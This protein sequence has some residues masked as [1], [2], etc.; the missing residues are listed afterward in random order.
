MLDLAKIRP[1]T[2]AAVRNEDG[3]TLL[4]L[5]AVIC[6][7]GVIAAIYVPNFLNHRQTVGAEV[8]KADLL[9][10]S[11]PVGAKYQEAPNSTVSLTRAMFPAVQA[12]DGTEWDVVSGPVGYCLSAWNPGSPEHKTAET[13]LLLEQQTGDCAALGVSGKAV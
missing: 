4:E 2:K 3:F 6:I 12:S 5:L 13:P 11:V 7:I 8:L 1:T 9:N 10:L